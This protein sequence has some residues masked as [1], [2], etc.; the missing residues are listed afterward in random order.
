MEANPYEAPAARVADPV[1]TGVEAERTAHLRHEARLQSVGWLYWLAA[2]G[3]IALAV[4]S[5][6]FKGRG[7]AESMSFLAVELVLTLIAAGVGWGFRSL[8]AWVR[9]PGSVLSGLGLLLFPFGTIVHGYIL[10]LMWCAKGRRVL[11]PA[12][13]EV[14]RQTPDLRYRRSVGDWIALVVIVGVPLGL[15]ALFVWVGSQLPRDY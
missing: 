2:L 14:R 1:V 6:V 13:A 4:V 10:W 11:S 15:L 3:L 7:D 9:I 5:Q 8:A 12:W